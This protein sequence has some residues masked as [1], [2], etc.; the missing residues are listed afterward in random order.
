LRAASSYTASRLGENGF[1]VID[2]KGRLHGYHLHQTFTSASVTKG[3]LLVAYLEHLQK[4]GLGLTA[5]GQAL[6]YPMIH[7]SDNHAATAI[8]AIVGDTGLQEVARKAGMTEFSFGHDWANEQISPADQ[9]R[10]FFRLDN[11]IPR[12]YRAYARGV[13]SGI[14][15]EES[16]GIPAAAR[17]RWSVYFKGGWR[18]TGLGHLVHQ[19][20]RLEQGRRSFELAVM[21]NGLPSEGY[22]IE[23]IRGV[24]SRL[25]G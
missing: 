5:S 9:V 20:A 8:E 12:Q 19:V 24:T 7:F 25:L 16:W 15:F 18:R 4:Q 21:T 10:L 11:L 13:L 3:M 17:P 23:T 22:G 1:A 6:L 14:A 2:T